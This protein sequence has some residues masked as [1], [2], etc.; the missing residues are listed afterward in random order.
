MRKEKEMKALAQ[1]RL[2][3]SLTL[4]KVKS[5]LLGDEGLEERIRLAVVAIAELELKLSII[6]TPEEFIDAPR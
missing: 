5:A 1:K 6:S 2:L 4:R 3:Q